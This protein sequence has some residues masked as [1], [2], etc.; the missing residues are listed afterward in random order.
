LAK[1]DFEGPRQGRPEGPRVAL[2][3]ASPTFP[4]NSLLWRMNQVE[5]PTQPTNYLAALSTDFLRTTAHA[6]GHIATSS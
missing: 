4:I 3:K 6:S 5:S 2:G 1:F